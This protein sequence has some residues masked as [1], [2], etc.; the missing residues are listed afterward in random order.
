MTPLLVYFSAE[1]NSQVL[2]LPAL[3]F[4]LILTSR[5]YTEKITFFNT[6]AT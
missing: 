1:I 3:K 2:A 4:A 5:A 6:F